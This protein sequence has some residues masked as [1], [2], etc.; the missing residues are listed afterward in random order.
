MV[1][2]GRW[3]N[4]FCDRLRGLSDELADKY[5]RLIMA[6]DEKKGVRKLFATMDS[7]DGIPPADQFP[8]LHEFFELTHRL[9]PGT[10]L[11]RIRRGEL[12]FMK[13]A[14]TGGFVLLAKSLPEGYAAPNLAEIL[15]ISDDLKSQTFKRLL[16]TLQ[17][18]LNVSCAGGFQHGGHAVITAQKLR[19]LHAGV[20]YLTDRYRPEFRQK[21]GIP[22]NLEDMLGTI[23]G[24]SFLVIEGWRKFDLGLT[25]QEENDFYYVWQ[26]FGR[27]MGIHPP[28]DPSSAEYMPEDVNDAEAFYEAYKRRHYVRA[29]ENPDGVSLAQANLRMMQ[30]MI[31]GVLRIFGLGLLPRIY[32][33]EL[34]GSDGCERIGIKPVTGHAFMKWS[35]M[36]VHDLWRPMEN[37]ESGSHHRFART[38][39]QGLIDQAYDGRVTF[40]IPTT[41]EEVRNLPGQKSM[42]H[43]YAKTG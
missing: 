37:L 5:L 24:F 22:V 31:P 12:I 39:F 38:L 36:K 6:D 20:R 8:E 3:T 17:T 11:E 40:S 26:T 2:N 16:G 34:M 27:L 42:I 4:E 15:A 1:S 41:L 29:N 10:D 25:S 19:L 7:N 14:F 33:V 28:D 35:L 23:M 32:M 18:V 30:R 13:H 21:Y 43:S 9:P